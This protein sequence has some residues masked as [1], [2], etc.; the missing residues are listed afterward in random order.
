MEL[1]YVLAL[2]KKMIDT[3]FFLF[4]QTHMF[5]LTFLRLNYEFLNVGVRPSVKQ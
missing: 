4:Q 1:P 5:F 2:T 3:I